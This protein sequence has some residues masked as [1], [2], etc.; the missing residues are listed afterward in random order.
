MPGSSKNLSCGV[1]LFRLPDAA[2]SG[3]ARTAVHIDP[4]LFVFVSPHKTTNEK[5]ILYW[6]SEEGI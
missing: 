1:R 2:L 6:V 3:S 5:A 4:F